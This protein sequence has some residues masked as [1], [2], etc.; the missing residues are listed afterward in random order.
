MIIKN[1]NEVDVDIMVLSNETKMDFV[2][3]AWSDDT[4]IVLLPGVSR[5]FIGCKYFEDDFEISLE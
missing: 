1:S 2:A 4:E 3:K 5:V